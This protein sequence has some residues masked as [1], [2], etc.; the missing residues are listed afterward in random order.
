MKNSSNQINQNTKESWFFLIF[1]ICGV[2]AIFL[3]TA[4]VFH[5]IG[6]NKNPK[7]SSPKCDVLEG[8]DVVYSLNGEIISIE[9]D[10]LLV[11]T[12]NAK[13]W[14]V[15]ISEDTVFSAAD[16]SEAGSGEDPIVSSISVS[17]L[18]QGDQ[19]IISSKSLKGKGVIEAD[20]ITVIEF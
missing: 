16:Y 14:E 10:Y 19:L 18:E 3:L 9:S 17:D 1:V 8:I 5:N 6:L 2:V 12:T 4:A 7:I 20:R 15:L 11:K 13:E